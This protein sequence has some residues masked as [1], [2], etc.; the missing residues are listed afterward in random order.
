MSTAP[1]VIVARHGQHPM[2]VVGLSLITNR[3][4][5]RYADD[6]VTTSRFGHG[7]DYIEAHPDHDTIVQTA[8]R[9]A[10]DLRLLVASFISQLDVTTAPPSGH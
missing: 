1:E 10:D 3:C 5:D 8:E 4:V 6:P 2:R 9:R 7:P